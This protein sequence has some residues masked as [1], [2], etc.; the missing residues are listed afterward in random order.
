MVTRALTQAEFGIWLGHQRARDPS[1]YNACEC[2]I[3][4]GDLDQRRF[5]C[6]LEAV[7]GSAPW[8]QAAFEEGPRGPERVLP[9]AHGDPPDPLEVLDFSD[10]SEPMNSLLELC[11]R[12][13]RTPLPFNRR[14]FRHGL[15]RLGTKK[16]AWVHLAHH[17]LLDG[18]GFQIVMQRV[19]EAYDAFERHAFDG[20]VVPLERVVAADQVYQASAACARDAEFWREELARAL[21]VPWAPLGRAALSHAARHRFRLDSSFLAQNPTGKGQAPID[22]FA[23]LVARVVHRETGESRFQLGVPV[24]LRLG[25]PAVSVPCMAMNI[26]PLRVERAGAPICEVSADIERRRK[27]AKPHERYRYEHMRSLSPA[28]DAKLFGPVVNFLP[29]ASDFRFSS[30]AA[31]RLPISAGP[32]E[33]IAFALSPRPSGFDLLVDV[34]PEV[35]SSNDVERLVCWLKEESEPSRYPAMA[36][37]GLDSREVGD[38]DGAADPL[39]RVFEHVRGA[40][41][42]IALEDG[43]MELSYSELFQAVRGVRRWLGAHGIEADAELPVALDLPQGL[44]AVLFVV[45]LVAH[46]VTYVALDRSHPRDR[47]RSVFQRAA[48]SRIVTDRPSVEFEQPGLSLMVPE[49]QELLELGERESPALPVVRGIRGAYVVFT[50]G[51]T[52]EPKGIFVGRKALAAFIRGACFTYLLAEGDRV[53]QFAPLSFDA[54]VEE[55]FV[56]LAS[57]GT[58]CV[59]SS[60][61]TESMGRF[62][63]EIEERSLTVLDL[64]T[65]FFHEWAL[66]LESGQLNLPKCVRLVII[67]GEAALSSR[68]RSIRERA[69]GVMLLNTYGPSEATVVAT[70]ARLDLL[71]AHT[72]IPIGLPLPG[73][74]A[75]VLDDAGR[76]LSGPAE[77]QLALRGNTLAAEYLGAPAETAKRFVHYPGLGRLYLTL[78]RVRRDAKGVLYFEGRVDD[79]FKVSGYR[80]VPSEIEQAL[81]AHPSVGQA[82]VFGVALDTG[83]RS[84]VAHVEP[85]VDVGVVRAFLRSRLPAPLVP[86]KIVSFDRLPRSRQGKLDRNAARSAENAEGR[87]G[88]SEATGT[89]GRVLAVWREVLGRSGFGFDDDFFAV[90]GSSLHVLQL[91]SRLSDARELRVADIFSHPTPRSQ[92]TLLDG[93]AASVSRSWPRCRDELLDF[94]RNELR[95]VSPTMDA[96]RIVL[97]GALG[98]VGGE[99]LRS[100]CLDT[101][102][103]IVCVVRADTRAGASTRLRA[104]VADLGLEADLLDERIRVLELDLSDPRGLDEGLERAG[105][106]DALVHSA[107]RVSLNRDY[108]SLVRENVEATRALL[109]AANRANAAFHH[110]STVAVSPSL[111]RVPEE[112]FAPHDGLRDGYQQ[113]KWHA[114]DLCAQAGRQGQR[115]AVY[116]LSRVTGPRRAPAVSTTDIFW[117]IARAS[118]RTGAWPD[119]AIRE[120]W[121]PA[122]EVGVDIV[123]LMKRGAATSP[124]SVYHLTGE[125]QVSWKDVFDAFSELGLS[126]PRLPLSEWLRAVETRAEDEDRA[127]LAFFELRRGA[128]VKEMS[129]VQ[130]R[131]RRCLRE[132]RPGIDANLVRAYC[133]SLLRECTS[134]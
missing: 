27:E 114:E 115:V 131:A 37:G 43:A 88:E 109:V 32:V 18:Y 112:F 65:A 130:E 75:F 49:I 87:S 125:Q 7:L 33:D 84:I 108:L 86:S 44:L 80:V 122:D 103:E 23:A 96:R 71:D 78:D 73:V 126:L 35:F 102:A 79:E 40:P 36:F 20:S 59:R 121:T 72:E 107:A 133:S 17:L 101:R 51:S 56:T 69:P 63:R 4:H 95:P 97:T 128:Q 77:G 68:V 39:E 120:N 106:F 2:V 62:T 64:P 82:M 6:S 60:A 117:R 98:L 89:L 21:G 28:S 58:L 5:Q 29:F 132:R 81:S 105:P 54:S 123:R 8:L 100:A 53:L 24:M 45:G 25:T 70:A 12:W 13:V 74:D 99:L 127:T 31:E 50:S 90:G 57:G 10:R 15:V 9:V 67:G 19:A 34:H 22:S 26:T 116:R 129:F 46:G 47:Y 134:I 124:G 11:D 111:D 93:S 118:L 48:P 85:A 91:A 41:S 110:V 30:L 1:V 55:I 3:L 14:L 16:F 76:V 42:A 119:L 38:A 83:E 52:G 66:R 94:G 61:M 104:R 92:A 113:S